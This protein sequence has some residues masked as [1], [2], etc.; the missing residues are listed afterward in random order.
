MKKEVVILIADDDDAHVAL[1]QRNLVRAGTVNRQLVFSNG[2]Q[3]LDFL[4]MRSQPCREPGTAYLLLLDIRMP[5][6]DG[7]EVLRQVKADP[8]LRK[9]PVIMV[10][11]T[12]DPLEVERCH[13]L[14]CSS[15]ITKPVDYE[16]FMEA[17][18]RLGMF[19]LVI[20]VPRLD[21]ED[22]PNQR[23]DRTH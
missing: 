13:R 10:T 18:R 6:V 2:E 14:G 15:Y 16:K 5:R 8:E 23:A 20:E 1:M 3:V 7:V 21:G 19:M 12:D 11:T 4:F 17:I 22:E 9:L